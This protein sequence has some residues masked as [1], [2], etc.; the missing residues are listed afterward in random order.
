MHK[1]LAGLPQVSHAE[2]VGHAELAGHAEHAGHAAHFTSLPFPAIHSPLPQ[3]THMHSH[4]RQLQLQT[5]MDAQQVCQIIR[6]SFPSQETLQDRV[7]LWVPSL[8]GRSAGGSRA[9]GLT[10]KPRF[11]SHNML[12]P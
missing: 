9:G 2:H 7:S 6:S 1:P 12:N 8:Q 3:M 11:F 5:Y 10:W 4:S